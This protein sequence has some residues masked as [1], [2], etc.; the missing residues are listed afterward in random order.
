MPIGI[1]GGVSLPSYQWMVF[2]D[3]ENFTIRGQKLAKD[4]SIELKEGKYFCKDTFLWFP[5]YN[6]HNNFM[7]DIFAMHLVLLGR[8]TT[9]VAQET[10]AI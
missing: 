9:L 5:R 2:V 3:G 8:L 1:S 7:G 10:R 6:A 4:N